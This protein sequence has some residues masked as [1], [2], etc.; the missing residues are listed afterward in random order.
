MVE[1][2]LWSILQV[3]VLVDIPGGNPKSLKALPMGLDSGRLKLVPRVVLYVSQRG[4]EQSQWSVPVVHG[5]RLGG[6]C[7]M[8]Q[9]ADS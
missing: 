7:K 3:S 5:A 1:L 4:S 8:V 2:K 6:F 9:V